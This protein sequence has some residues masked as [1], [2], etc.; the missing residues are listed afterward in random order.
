M[1]QLSRN[2]AQLPIFNEESFTRFAQT[3]G[4]Q[5]M[6]VALRWTR[7]GQTAEDVVQEAL[8]RTWQSR[9]NIKESPRAWFFKILWHVFLNQQKQSQLHRDRMQQLEQDARSGSHDASYQRCDD[10]DEIAGLLMTLTQFDR[11]LLAM[12]YGEDFT[13][14]EIATITGMPLGTVKSRIHRAL[15]QIRSS[16]STPS[17]VG[18][19]SAGGSTRANKR[20]QF[21]AR[22]QGGMERER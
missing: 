11:H 15:K 20:R 7:H 1:E 19:R 22:N 8:T 9:M 18:S 4:P 2:V 5:A 13:M 21:D 6:R 14:L 10:Q 3:I 16:V 12:R 17:G